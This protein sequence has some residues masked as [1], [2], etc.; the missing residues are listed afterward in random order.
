MS[1]F[2]MGTG[3]GP[4][5]S[6]GQGRGAAAAGDGRQEAPKVKAANSEEAEAR[7]R[8]MQTAIKEVKKRF[9]KNAMFK[10][11][12]LEEAATTL[13]RNLQIGGHKSGSEA[14]EGKGPVKPNRKK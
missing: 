13:E 6:A 12:D 8:D 4:K 1:L 9:G 11:M 7:D 3:G 14:P 2:D 5:G 10:A